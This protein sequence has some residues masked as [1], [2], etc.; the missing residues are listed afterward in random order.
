M[1]EFPQNSFYNPVPL[2]QIESLEKWRRLPT[3][4]WKTGKIFPR[5]TSWGKIRR[6]SY[7]KKW[8]PPGVKDILPFLARMRP[9]TGLWE[10]VSFSIFGT[11]EIFSPC[12]N[13]FKVFASTAL[14]L[15]NINRTLSVTQYHLPVESTDYFLLLIS[16][17]GVL[18][19][20]VSWVSK[21]LGVHNPFPFKYFPIINTLYILWNP[22]PEAYLYT[23]LFRLLGCF[24]WRTS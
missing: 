13:I 17:S 11:K 1:S 20:P 22:N 3:S 2:F 21:F 7:A 6:I 8:N 16:I 12:R 4:L 19:V 5:H 10:L 24:G 14:K 15:F 18:S 9:S 23:F